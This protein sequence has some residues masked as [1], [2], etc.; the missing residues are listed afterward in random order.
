[1][2]NG[3]SVWGVVS[4]LAK[5]GLGLVPAAAVY[6]SSSVPEKPVPSEQ[7]DLPLAVPG[8]GTDPPE[9]PGDG[10]DPPEKI[11]FPPAKICLKWQRVQK[12]GAGLQNL[13]NTC[14][15]NSVLQCLTYTAPLS[16]YLISREH[17]ET[18]HSQDFCMMCVM[19]THISMALSN[20]G[21][22]I[23]PS[24][25]VN[26]LRRIS[27][28]F[29]YGSQEDAHEF[30]RYTVD[31]MQKSCLRGSCR[32]D[33]HTQATTLIHQVFGGYLRSRVTC[34]SC[35]AVSDTYDQYLDLTLEIK[36]AHSVNQAL[37][38]FV[39]PEQLDGDN[40]YKC[41][42]CKQMVTASKRFTI[43]RT[44]NVL[45]LSLKRFAS[46]NGG[47]LS[48]EIKYP[49]YL[50]LR[51]YTSDPNGE[52][53]IYVL[54]AV[55]IHTGFS[56]HGGHYYCYVKACNDQWYLMNDSTVS[57]TDIR[58]VLNQQ[59]YLLFYVRSQ[60]SQ[61]GAN[62][63]SLHAASPSSPQPSSSQRAGS[64]K[65]TL[66]GPP[67]K[68]KSSKHMNGKK[69]PKNQMNNSVVNTNTVNLKRP[70]LGNTVVNRQTVIN[71][72]N[73]KKQKITISINKYQGLPLPTVHKTE[74]LNKP[75]PSSTITK[76]SNKPTSNTS[77]ALVRKHSPSKL[78]PVPVVNGS[79]KAGS[80]L[81]V[82]YGADSS[83]NSEEEYKGLDSSDWNGKSVN[84]EMS[85]NG[86]SLH[87]DKSSPCNSFK[88]SSEKE[89]P[90]IAAVDSL[91]RNIIA[92]SDT[93]NV[94]VL[95]ITHSHNAG[96][97][98]E[99]SS[100][101]KTEELTQDVDTILPLSKEKKPLMICN[102]TSE[103]KSVE[104]STLYLSNGTSSLHNTVPWRNGMDQPVKHLADK[105][106][107][108]E[109]QSTSEDPP[110]SGQQESHTTD[111]HISKNANTLSEDPSTFNNTLANSSEEGDDKETF[112]KPII[113][114]YGN[115]VPSLLT[116]S[117]TSQSIVKVVA[118]L[119]TSNGNVN[120]IS[121]QPLKN[122]DPEKKELIENGVEKSHSVFGDAKKVKRD[123]LRNGR[124][125]SD[126]SEGVQEKHTASN[127]ER[128]SHSR[129]RTKSD[130][131][132][133][134]HHE[135][136][137][138]DHYRRNSPY[139]DCT[140]HSHTRGRSRSRDRYEKN[141][142]SSSKR[143]RSRSRERNYQDK[144]RR[145]DG[146]RHYSDY[147]TSHGYRDFQDRRSSYEDKDYHSKSYN[148]NRSRWSYYP[149]DKE[150]EY[151][152]SPK[153]NNYYSS[154]LTKHS[155]KYYEKYND[156]VDYYPADKH[157]RIRKSKHRHSGDSDL[158]T[159]SRHKL[160]GEQRH[161][162]KHRWSSSSESSDCEVDTKRKK[163]GTNGAVTKDSSR[164]YGNAVI[165]SSEKRPL[166]MTVFHDS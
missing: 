39:R 38:Q 94:N 73:N 65:S 67:R 144:G 149:R 131:Y 98:T 139:K 66:V 147:R 70:P 45:T 40:A 83:E 93:K 161:V 22:V 82:P 14:F 52:P 26:D 64:T 151:F 20:S 125:R 34:L 19:Q 115:G 124:C 109:V 110:A 44:S 27:K 24:A 155:D 159:E 122:T 49:E 7:N 60:N 140:K 55:L 148:S 84:G 103:D 59:A 21:G 18:C 29:R 89:E 107:A 77:M 79:C 134:S 85:K 96:N 35:K 30:L 62:L 127:R 145:Y 146:Y 23:K 56:C 87:K 119:D 37:E 68:I 130:R 54:Y 138:R 114:K 32:L 163:I 113:N 88:T 105:P 133:P 71:I 61:S 10:I 6:S 48:K 143:A 51:P 111:T 160:N 97:P 42:K 28:N 117:N 126:S 121:V 90:P 91:S 81:L 100:L 80:S 17:S 72:P 46:F 102:N 104:K 1:M 36:M 129:E 76:H 43:H 157:A 78:Y 12:V 112:D 13:G 4:A 101:K 25:V 152:S 150:H 153:H 75:T 95:E 118:K 58:T 165:T 141:W 15:V 33:R 142:Y 120:K 74:S 2:E 137:H 162:R 106:K 31:E 166:K 69:S 136:R 128:Q 57:T 92:C 108:E 53:V 116:C 3:S 164:V 99:F 132:R 123:H 9:K 63:Y 154:S 47:K 50:D 156:A 16:N 8:D 135:Y 158:E 41:S 86:L 5:I 11:L